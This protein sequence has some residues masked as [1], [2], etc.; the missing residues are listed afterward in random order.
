MCFSKHLCSI[1]H[2]CTGAPNF[3]LRAAASSFLNE[4]VEALLRNCCS[5]KFGVMTLGKRQELAPV[6]NDV[7]TQIPTCAYINMMEAD[8]VYL[9]VAA[10]ILAGPLTSFVL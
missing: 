5:A 4:S 6:L 3:L 7:L 10:D 1:R 9:N 2:A 8:V